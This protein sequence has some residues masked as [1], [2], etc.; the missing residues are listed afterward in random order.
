MPLG[1][2]GFLTPLPGPR[3]ARGAGQVSVPGAPAPESGCDRP[4]VSGLTPRDRGQRGHH[5]V[6]RGKGCR[7]WFLQSQLWSL[8]RTGSFMTSLS[9]SSATWGLST[10]PVRETKIPENQHN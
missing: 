10:R 4:A 9:C 1:V 6:C 2:S 5:V 7:A 8:N 3:R